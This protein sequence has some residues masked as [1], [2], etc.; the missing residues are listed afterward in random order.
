MS[1]VKK[2]RGDNCAI[3]CEN[4]L[5]NVVRS[6]RKLFQIAMEYVAI[7]VH[8]VESFEGFPVEVGRQIFRMA[9]VKHVFLSIDARSK[10][11]MSKFT[12]TYQE[13]VLSSMN[14]SRSNVSLCLYEEHFSV[15]L[16]LRKLDISYCTLGDDHDFLLHISQ[17]LPN[18]EYLSLVKSGT[19]DK[20]LRL[21]TIPV[22]AKKGGL[23]KLEILH[24]AGNKLVTDAGI[25]F[26]KRF[27]NLKCID[28]SDTAVQKTGVQGLKKAGF[29]VIPRSQAT[30]VCE[31]IENEGWAA[32]ILKDWS[33]VEPK[34][35]C[36][37]R[38]TQQ[39]INFYKT[40]KLHQAEDEDVNCYIP[41]REL[42]FCR[43]NK[44]K[45][46]TFDS[47]SASVLQSYNENTGDS[48]DDSD[49]LKLYM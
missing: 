19:T 16:H 23:K 5:N 7:N 35:W 3:S 43:F 18:L 10:L 2:R 11:A 39:G 44:N 12:D 1:G 24:L 38:P 20:S 27:P 31:T 21:L 33:T 13:L 48:E 49:L 25:R 41:I 15:F 29:D 9:E 28:L 36:Q 45:K 22:G 47:T 4:D 26:I 17:S 14:L 6:P 32:D 30:A 46:T 37:P 8:N 40:K 42:N 34:S